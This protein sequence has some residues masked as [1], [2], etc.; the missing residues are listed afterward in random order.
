MSQERHIEEGDGSRNPH[1]IHKVMDN[2]RSYMENLCLTPA[3]V[4]AIKFKKND[5]VSLE[6]ILAH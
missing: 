1:S 2:R 6:F 3:R 4:P 5:F